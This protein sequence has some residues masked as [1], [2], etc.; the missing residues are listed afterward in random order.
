[1]RKK[2]NLSQAELE[3]ILFYRL[4]KVNSET[5]IEVVGR[6]FAPC[7]IEVIVKESKNLHA[8]TV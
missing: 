2:T 7:E 8:R 5:L 6:V 1:M 4:G 3:D